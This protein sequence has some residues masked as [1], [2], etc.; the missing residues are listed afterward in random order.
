VPVAEELKEVVFD[1][2]SAESKSKEKNQNAA[3]KVPPIMV[4]QII[5]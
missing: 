5:K 3:S 1:E 2:H 4:D